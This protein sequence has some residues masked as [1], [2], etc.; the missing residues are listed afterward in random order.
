MESLLRQRDNI[1]LILLHISHDILIQHD[2][3][4]LAYKLLILL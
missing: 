4:C 3:F 1:A 2:Y